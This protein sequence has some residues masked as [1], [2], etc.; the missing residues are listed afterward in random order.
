MAQ[1]DVLK[2][3]VL[4]P[5]QRYLFYSHRELKKPENIHIRE[6]DYQNGW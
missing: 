4:S 6:A 3:L 5:T 1:D 2:C